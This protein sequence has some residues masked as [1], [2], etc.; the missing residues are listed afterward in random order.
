MRLQ[1]KTAFVTAAG[2][3][4]GRAITEAFIAEG[5]SV[6]ATDIRGELLADLT[7]ETQELDA[8]DRAGVLAAITAKEPEVLVNCAGFVHA[9]T[10]LDASVEEFDF[11][12]ELNVKTMMHTIKAALPPMLRRGS[13][14]IINI[15][16]VASSMRG[17]PNRFIYS[18]SKGA[19][20]GLT[21]SVAADFITRGVRC[22]CICPGTVESPSLHDRMNATGDHEQ[23]MKDFIARQ[24]MGRMAQP[25]EIAHVAVYLASDESSYMTGQE[26]A[27]DGGITL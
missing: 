21:K 5:A 7:C 25:E 6:V 17:L 24:P 27:I 18:M 16:S 19:V 3:G 12:A 15:A 4:I 9:G 23:A 2:Q 11:A 26:I 1:G 8:T 14:S 22:N 13:G 20:I 10:V